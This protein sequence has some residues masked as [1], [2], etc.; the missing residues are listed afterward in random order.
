[1]VE[2]ALLYQSAHRRRQLEQWL[3]ELYPSS[4]TLQ[5]STEPA[6]AIADSLAPKCFVV[7]QQLKGHRYSFAGKVAKVL[8]SFGDWCETTLGTVALAEVGE[9]RSWT[10]A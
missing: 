6:K 8:E 7:G 2:G 1:M 4:F 3:A 9:G 5:P 10:F